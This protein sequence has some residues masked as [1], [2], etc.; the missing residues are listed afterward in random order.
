MRAVSGGRPLQSGQ[1]DVEFLHVLLAERVRD[2][3][4]QPVV[5]AFVIGEGVVLVEASR[6]T[7]LD[8]SEPPMMSSASVLAT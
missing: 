7:A 1:S 5:D 3:G 8:A 2:V 6:A 4:P